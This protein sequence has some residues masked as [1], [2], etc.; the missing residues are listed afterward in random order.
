M[1]RDVI[2]KNRI[3]QLFSSEM[4]LQEIQIETR[5]GPEIISPGLFD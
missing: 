5:K 4:F 2:T 1:L 3:C